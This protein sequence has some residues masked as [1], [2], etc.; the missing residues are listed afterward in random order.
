MNIYRDKTK[1]KRVWTTKDNKSMYFAFK[2]DGKVEY[3]KGLDFDDLTEIKHK[4]ESTGDV[5]KRAAV[6]MTFGISEEIELELPNRP[7]KAKRE[8][9]R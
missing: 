1:Y 7:P 3:K 9:Y 6:T 4:T 2:N 8:G 5:F